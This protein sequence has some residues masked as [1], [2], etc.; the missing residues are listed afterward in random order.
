M[1]SSLLSAAGNVEYDT[2]TGNI[3]PYLGKGE[4]FLFALIGFAITFIGIILLIFIMWLFGK[5]VTRLGKVQKQEKADAPAAAAA[6]VEEGI[7]EEVRVAI[8]AAIAAYYAGKNSS[9]EFK[10]KRIRKL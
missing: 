1:L 6:A 10:V 5:I 8:V 2:V 7:S 9:C 3:V 4:V